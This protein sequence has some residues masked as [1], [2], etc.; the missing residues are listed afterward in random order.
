VKCSICGK[1]CQESF[2]N[3]G[4]FCCE[5]HKQEVLTRHHNFVEE[6]RREAPWQMP[7]RF[8]MD[9]FERFALKLEV[10][11]LDALSP[12]V[13]E[14][15][16]QTFPKLL[17]PLQMALELKEHILV[18][19]PPSHVALEPAGGLSFLFHGGAYHFLQPIPADLVVEALRK[20]GLVAV[21]GPRP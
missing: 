5:D 1:E 16:R 7:D 6:L 9:D 8:S 17:N 3:L 13:R 4:A 2:L 14:L 21:L 19:L 11:L 20:A 10:R 12:S 15:Y 18:Q